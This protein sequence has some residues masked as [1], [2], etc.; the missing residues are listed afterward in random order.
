M[1]PNFV[2]TTVANCLTN[3]I[4]NQTDFT[5]ILT[6]LNSSPCLAISGVGIFGIGVEAVVFVLSL[7]IMSNYLRLELAGAVASFFA[8]ILGVIYLMPA[9]LLDPNWLYVF[10]ATTIGCILLATLHHGNHPYD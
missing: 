2:L 4:S 1:I 9:G 10:L 8:L 3:S 7:M 6:G 5:S